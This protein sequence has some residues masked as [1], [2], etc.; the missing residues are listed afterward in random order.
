MISSD[1]VVFACVLE[2]VFFAK[3]FL[4][5]KIFSRQSFFLPKKSSHANFFSFL[6]PNFFSFLAPNFSETD[7]PLNKS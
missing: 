4:P 3:I 5:K 1:F 7:D 6:T 2:K